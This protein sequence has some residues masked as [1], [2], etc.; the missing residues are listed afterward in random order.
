M[1]VMKITDAQPQKNNANRKSVFIDYTYALSMDEED[2][3]KMKLS[4]GQEISEQQIQQIQE[5][6]NYSK[7]KKKALRYI[8]F[9]MRTALEVKEKL[10]QDG[11]TTEIAEQVIAYFK[12][13]DYI[14]DDTYTYKYIRDSVQLKKWGAKRIIMELQVKG[15]AQE[16]ILKHIETQ[17]AH[18]NEQLILLIQKK[19]RTIKSHDEKS[20]NRIRNYFIRRGYSLYSINTCIKKIMNDSQQPTTLKGSGL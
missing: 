15:V 4:V 9:K 10:K 1:D 2:W 6:C 8:T 11:Y 5:V 20:L 18:E 17:T 14:N 3:L 13:L 12:E 19:F 7:A 16:T